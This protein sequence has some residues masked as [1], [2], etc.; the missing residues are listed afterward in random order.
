M[1]KFLLPLI[2]MASL[3]LGSGC[4]AR[5]SREEVPVRDRLITFIALIK[6]SEEG[7]IIIDLGLSNAGNPIPA[8]DAFHGTWQ[9]TADN[10]ELRAA[11]EVNQRSEMASNESMLVS[12]AGKLEPG[13]YRLVW[14]APGYGHTVIDFDVARAND[15]EVHVG[16]QQIFVT[17]A[18]PPR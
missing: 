17:T 10:G 12:W 6:D 13:A 3:L 11:G 8:D 15:N 1:K 9:L 14:G 18:D 2:L 7:E 16:N 4:D 5:P